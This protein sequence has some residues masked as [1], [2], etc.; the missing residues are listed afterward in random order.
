MSL[1]RRNG[2]AAGAPAA[3]PVLGAGGRRCDVY[4]PP[5]R[6]HPG[7]LQLL[8]RWGALRIRPWRLHE[9]ELGNT[10]S[11]LFSWLPYLEGAPL[12]EQMQEDGQGCILSRCGLY[13]LLN[14]YWVFL[15]VK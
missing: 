14:L 2:E 12:Y 7:A 1:L 13:L 3:A 11:N 5:R 4:A 6:A 10:C 8:R 15:L 9:G